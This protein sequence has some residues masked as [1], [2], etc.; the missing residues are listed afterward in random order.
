MLV[1]M[2]ELKF[3]IV[4]SQQFFKLGECDSFN[5]YIWQ[6]IFVA[7]MKVYK[8][9]MPFVVENLQEF[10]LNNYMVSCMAIVDI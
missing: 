8:L 3:K 6:G 7:L 5:C 10:D 9:S 1:L 4:F 2:L